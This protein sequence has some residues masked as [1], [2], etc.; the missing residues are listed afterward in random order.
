MG[1]RAAA[2]VEVEHEAEGVARA[3]ARPC[4]LTAS[5]APHAKSPHAMMETVIIRYSTARVARHVMGAL[6]FVAGGVFLLVTGE[7][8]V[9]GWLSIVF[10]GEAGDRRP[11]HLRSRAQSRGDRVARHPGRL[12]RSRG[13]QCVHLPRAARLGEVH[14]P[15]LAGET[16]DRATQQDVRIHRVFV[17]PGGHRRRSRPTET[18]D[19]RRGGG[20]VSLRR[21]RDYFSGTVDTPF[22]ATKAKS[23]SSRPE[24][25]ASLVNFMVTVFSNWSWTTALRICQALGSSDRISRV[26]VGSGRLG[27]RSST[28]LA[29][30]SLGCAGFSRRT[31]K[32]SRS[33]P[34]PFRNEPAGPASASGAGPVFTWL[35]VGV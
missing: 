29:S 15:A 31:L 14:E 28:T 24:L 19:P 5:E 3:R 2:A 11:R 22:G 8:E 7:D 20:A 9:F 30:A 17:E 16:A 34:S 12:R 10:F 1:R 33:L 27:V 26:S 35:S 23:L 13:G 4:P 21:A 32:C 18:A 25:I 6:V